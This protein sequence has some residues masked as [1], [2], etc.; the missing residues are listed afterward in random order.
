MRA[1]AATATLLVAAASTAQRPTCEGRLAAVAAPAATLAAPRVWPQ[2]RSDGARRRL[3][4]C[5]Y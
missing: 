2:R 3:T 5:S 1:Q 4:A